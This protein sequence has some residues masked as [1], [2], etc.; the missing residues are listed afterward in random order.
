MH[1]NGIAGSY[2]SLILN[3]LRNLH[4]GYTNLHSY[5]LCVR[6]PFLYNLS[7]ACHFYLLDYSLSNWGEMIRHC[8]FWFAFSDDQWCEYFFKY[9]AIIYLLLRHVLSPFKIIRLFVFYPF[10]KYHLVFQTFHSLKFS[11]GRNFIS[12]LI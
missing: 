1:S 7:S 10:L 5:Q 6:G 8:G 12:F 11:E 4:I 2:N 3:F 9:L